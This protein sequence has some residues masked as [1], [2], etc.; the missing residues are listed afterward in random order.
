MKI[1]IT[2]GCGF[3]GTSLAKTYLEKGAEITIFDLAPK[4]ELPK[5][6]AGHIEY[7]NGNVSNWSE[8]INAVKSSSA[9]SIFHLAGILSA[10]SEKNPWK[11]YKVNVEG[12]FNVF[13]AARIFNI[14][15]VIF[16]SSMGVYGT[17]GDETIDDFSFRDPI[18]IYGV[19]KIFGELLGKYYHRKFGIDFRAV[20]FPQ[21]IGPGVKS[22]GFGQ[23]APGMIEAAFLGKPF[24]V[25]V[26][27]DTAIPLLYIKD[28][29]RSLIELHDADENLITTRVYNLG[30]ILPPPTA[31]DLAEI[32]KKYIPLAKIDFKPDPNA[33][34]I[35]K[36]IPKNIDGSNAEKEWGWEIKY[37]AEDTVKDFLDSLG[38]D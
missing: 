27:E 29:I 4:D 15:K 36:T 32:V 17:S 38:S 10:P 7:I 18:L 31:K 28:A 25:W 37:S 14:E 20:R 33:V 8:V 24:E 13:E 2:G 23:Y 30:Q 16:S 26:P 22:G 11:S 21:L 6:I 19:G 34:E 35:L 1:L 9:D 12:T 3:I 5:D